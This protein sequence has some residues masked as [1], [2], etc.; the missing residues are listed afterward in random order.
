MALF[1]G[2]EP[3]AG[4]VEDI[5]AQAHETGA[6]LFMTAVN[7]GEVWYCSARARSESTADERVSD[8]LKLGVEVVPADWVLSRQA[9]QFKAEGGLSYADCFALAL[10]KVNKAELVTGD[11]EFKMF[12]K[13][14]RIVWV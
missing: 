11:V 10:A 13:D 2:E 1:Q 9:A 6:S 14:V 12:E 8:V 4:K 7:L 3:A 5:L